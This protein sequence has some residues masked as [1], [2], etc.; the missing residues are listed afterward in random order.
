LTVALAFGSAVR[1]KKTGALFRN[2]IGLCSFA[3]FALT[4]VAACGSDDD[5]DHDGAGEGEATG[6]TCPSGSTL[7]YANF[8]QPF[9]AKYCTRCHSTNA[10]D[11]HGAPSDHNFDSEAL[12]LA[13]REHI[14]EHAAAGPNA[15]NRLMPPDGDAPTDDE[16]KKLGEWLA[17]AGGGGD[18]HDAGTSMDG[19][20]SP[21]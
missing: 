7:T 4:S 8:G 9:M 15:T 16:R 13:M 5:H 19:S 3:L 6:A 2:R 20:S 12:I 21:R 17:C 10:T 1:M 14:D 18:D 11:R